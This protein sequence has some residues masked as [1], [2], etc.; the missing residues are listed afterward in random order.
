MAQT[1][2]DCGYPV[3]FATDEESGE[4]IPLDERATQLTG[5]DRYFFTQTTAPQKV[6]KMAAQHI[7]YGYGDHRKTCP[8]ARRLARL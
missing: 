8:R 5:N 3:V 4:R 1:C 2:P 7:G 6:R